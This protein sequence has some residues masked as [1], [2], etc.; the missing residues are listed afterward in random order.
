MTRLPWCCFCTDEAKTTMGKAEVPGQESASV[1]RSQ[2]GRCLC[3]LNTYPPK[4]QPW[5]TRFLR[6]KGVKCEHLGT[7]CS[8]L[9][10]QNLRPVLYSCSTG[11]LCVWAPFLRQAERQVQSFLKKAP[12]SCLSGIGCDGVCGQPQN[13]S[14]Q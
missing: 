9:G 2:Q 5:E 14:A 11:Q 7:S 10:R 3:R 8:R 12:K 4:P 1:L 6:V 13:S